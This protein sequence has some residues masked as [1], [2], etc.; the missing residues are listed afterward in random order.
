[1]WGSFKGQKVLLS[2][3]EHKHTQKKNKTKNNAPKDPTISEIMWIIL[4]IDFVSQ[5]IL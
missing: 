1:M 4:N 5:K 2:K 3:I